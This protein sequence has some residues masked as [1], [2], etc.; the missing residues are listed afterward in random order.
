MDKEDRLYRSLIILAAIC[1]FPIGTIV[2]GCYFLVAVLYAHR[3]E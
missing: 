3:K 2:I 1:L